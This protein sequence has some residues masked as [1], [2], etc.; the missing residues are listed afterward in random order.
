MNATTKME[1][2]KD[3]KPTMSRQTSTRQQAAQ[4]EGDKEREPPV[5]GG[6]VKTAKKIRCVFDDSPHPFA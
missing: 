2:S 1:T 6:S 4:H 3:A 5:G